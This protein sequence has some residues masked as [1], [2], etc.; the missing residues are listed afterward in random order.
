VIDG[1]TIESRISPHFI[2]KGGC[3]TFGDKLPIDLE[4]LKE[5]VTVDLK[6]RFPKIWSFKGVSFSSYNEKMNHWFVSFTF[7][8]NTKDYV[9]MQCNLKGEVWPLGKVFDEFDEQSDK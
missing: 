2:T 6:N 3:W 1:K 8:S 5:L 4:K 7:Q 9:I